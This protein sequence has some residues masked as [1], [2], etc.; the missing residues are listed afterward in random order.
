MRPI[1]LTM[2]AV[3]VCSSP[4]GFPIA[5]TGSPTSTPVYGVRFRNR[6]KN[7]SDGSSPG[8]WMPRSVRFVFTLTTAGFSRRASSTHGDRPFPRAPR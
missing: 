8:T 7:G 3:T 4:K 5:M 1:A 2:P 6:L